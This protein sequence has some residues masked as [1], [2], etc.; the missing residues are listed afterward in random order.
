MRDA[1]TEKGWTQGRLAA[2]LGTSQSAVAR[3]EQGRQNL[4]LKMVQRMETIFGRS[5]LT[6]GGTQKP[7]ITHLRVVGGRELSGSVAVNSSKNAGVA[8]L[9]GN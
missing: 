8:L 4:S 7:K 6:V 2:E 1:R 3:M 5:I 9:I